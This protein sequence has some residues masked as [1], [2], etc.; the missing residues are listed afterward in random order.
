MI[1]MGFKILI[2][3]IIVKKEYHQSG[4]LG[5]VKANNFVRKPSSINIH[6]MNHYIYI[7]KYS[8]QSIK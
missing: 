7:F 2:V 8:I 6:H 4:T 5:N 1:N 3:N